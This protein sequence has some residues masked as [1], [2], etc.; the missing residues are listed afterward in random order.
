MLFMANNDPDISEKI[1]IFLSDDEKIKSVGEMLTN[2]SSRAI[3]QLLFSEELSANDISQRTAISLQLVKYHLNKM[4]AV[5]MVRVSKT[6]KNSKGHDMKFYQATKFA[7]VILPSKVS[8]RAKE[9]KS[10]IRSFKT[11]YKFA[12]IGVAAVAGLI[13]LSFL[14]QEQAGTPE[15]HHLSEQRMYESGES[16][17]EGSGQRVSD[18]TVAGES[19]TLEESLELT[20]RVP[21]PSPALGA[22]AM[23]GTGL[24]LGFVVLGMVAGGLAAY[25]YWRARSRTKPAEKNR[26]R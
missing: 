25:F 11:I 2:S 16:L 9:S 13:S 22:P 8:D 21:E 6:K 23:D 20:A 5:G 19:H 18:T 4:Q 17:P 14:Q 7:I 15:G 24:V 3:L 12:G 26:P 1:E 10:L